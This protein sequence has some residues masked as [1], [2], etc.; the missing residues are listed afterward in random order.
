[1]PNMISR[2]P[3]LFVDEHGNEKEFFFRAG[4]IGSK[5]SSDGKFLEPEYDYCITGFI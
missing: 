2:F 1:M 4:L 3:F 5:I